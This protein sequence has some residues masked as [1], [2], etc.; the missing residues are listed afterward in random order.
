MVQ[1]YPMYL[2]LKKTK[3][4]TKIFQMLLLFQ[5]QRKRLAMS[6]KKFK[7]SLLG[8]LELMQDD[9]TPK[10]RK[11][12]KLTCKTFV[13]FSVG[14][15]HEII[16]HLGQEPRTLNQDGLENFFSALQ[17]YGGDNNN[18]TAGQFT[19]AFKTCLLDGLCSSRTTSKNY[20]DDEGRLLSKLGRFLTN[21]TRK[22]STNYCMMNSCISGNKID[23]D[24]DSSLTNGSSDLSFTERQSVANVTGFI[25]KK[26]MSSVCK[27]CDVCRGDLSSE[28]DVVSVDGVSE[29]HCIIDAQYAGASLTATWPC[30]CCKY[31]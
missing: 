17:Q 14:I 19:A 4:P 3:K 29:V 5:E 23:D 25:G 8:E 22:T 2:L 27:G 28:P 30:C 7:K 31:F 20:E 12:L 1:V 16:K 26:L 24:D 13:N 10:K 6:Q 11:M 18:P 9:I 21:G 15:N